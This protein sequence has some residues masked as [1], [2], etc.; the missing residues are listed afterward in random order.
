M[1]A[2]MLIR[3][4]VNDYAAWRSVYDSVE[5][6]RQRFGCTGA[7]VHRDPIDENDVFV[8]HRFPSLGQAQGFA[9]S[10][11][12]KNAMG[13]AGVAGPPRIEIVMEV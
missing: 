3:H 8:L 12:L 13:N 6:L 7:E 5:P 9:E 2:T 10:D 1:T 11:E 4:Q